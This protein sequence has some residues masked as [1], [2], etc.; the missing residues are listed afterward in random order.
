M[1]GDEINK[2]DALADLTWHHLDDAYNLTNPDGANLDLG[3]DF[4][5]A[6]LGTTC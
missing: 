3:F 5:N 4:I 2:T 6:A 1:N